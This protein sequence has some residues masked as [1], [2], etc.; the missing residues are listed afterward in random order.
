METRHTWILMSLI[1]I[2]ECTPL[3]GLDNYSMDNHW[4]LLGDFVF[5]RRTDIHNKKLVKDENKHQCANQCPNFTVIDNAKLVNDFD[6]APGYRVGLTYIVDMNMGFEWN[7]LYLQPWHGEKKVRGDQ[8]LSFPFSHSDYTRDFHDASVAIAEYESHF[9]DLEF[10]YWCYFTPRRVDFFALSGLI[11]LRYFHWDEGFELKMFNPPDKSSY[12]IQTENRIFGLQFGLDFQMNPVRWLSWG[13]S[14][15]VGGMVDHS[16]QDTFLGDLD[17]KITLRDFEKQKREVGIYTDVAA[18]FAIHC[19][20]NFN[21][22]AG[23]QMM[24]F[25]GLTLAPEQISKRTGKN[26]GKKDYDHGT[27]IIHGMFAGVVF[28]F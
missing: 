16:E 18:D 10:N 2:C 23:Y 22:H 9:W 14:A 4:E 25:S 21:F 5:M 3:I 27:A 24:F 26:A 11:G 17:N 6:F 7:F 1:S 19:N 28:A 15:K 12:D 20:K 8:S 13:F